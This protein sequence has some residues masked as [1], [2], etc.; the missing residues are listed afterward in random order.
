M[1]SFFN[2][3][4][5]KMFKELENFRGRFAKN[6]EA[7]MKSIEEAIKSGELKGNWDVQKIDEP[8]VKGYVVYGR[9][10]SNQPLEPLNPFE[11]LEPWKR[12]PMPSRPLE[13][14]ENTSKEIREP[15]ID[16]FDEKKT[17]KIYV[18]LPGEEKDGIQLNVTEGKA[19]VKAKNFYKMIDLPTRDLD[20]EKTSSK[21]KNGVLEVTIPK[22]EMPPEKEPR[23]IN[24]E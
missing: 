5:E 7:E 1:D 18:E 11:P 16:V 12:Q 20:I 19:E 4:I 6:M 15:I 23:K 13:L 17:R 8:G 21:Y 2:F 10:E 24:I 9:Y 14:S 3:D 22:K